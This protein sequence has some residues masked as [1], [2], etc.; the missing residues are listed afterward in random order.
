MNQVPSDIGQ[1]VL[2]QAGL[3]AVKK[4]V[5]PIAQ[6]LCQAVHVRRIYAR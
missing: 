6:Q 3:Y 5:Y 4:V 2:P 1:Y